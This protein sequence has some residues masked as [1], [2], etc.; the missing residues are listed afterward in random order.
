[1]KPTINYRAAFVAAIVQ[2]A[3][4]VLWYSPV[5][6]VTR[7]LK[8]TG[9]AADMAQQLT[10]TQLATV[11][12]GSLVAFFVC[13]CVMAQFAHY[14]NAKNAKE[15]AQLSLWLWLGFTAT[16]L[17]VNINY[18]MKPLSLFLIDASYW[19]IS[20]II[21]GMIIATWKKKTA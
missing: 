2:F 10:R 1:M 8:D 4:G 15:G 12:G 7:W 5:L 9:L 14:V 6:F 3:I 20:M 17:L 16:T 19:L 13:Y 21:G 11:Y 18:Q